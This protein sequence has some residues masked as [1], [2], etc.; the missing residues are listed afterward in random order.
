MTQVSLQETHY[1]PTS[2]PVCHQI[3]LVRLRRMCLNPTSTY[4]CLRAVPFRAMKTGTGVLCLC[5]RL[6]WLFRKQQG[7]HQKVLEGCRRRGSFGLRPTSPYHSVSIIQRCFIYILK[8]Y[9]QFTVN[10]NLPHPDF[11]VFSKRKHVLTSPCWAILVPGWLEGGEKNKVKRKIHVLDS[12]E[13][14]LSISGDTYQ[15][16]FGEVKAL[17]FITRWALLASSG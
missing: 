4:L 7:Y 10:F 16:V 1:S 3:E 8:P 17:L 2:T 14:R 12:R 9:T 13:Q 11:C 15:R 6:C 5:V